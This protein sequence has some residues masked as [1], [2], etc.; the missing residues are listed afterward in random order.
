MGGCG[1]AA[2]VPMDPATA[3]R[4]HCGGYLVTVVAGTGNAVRWMATVHRGMRRALHE[5]GGQRTWIRASSNWYQVWK[6]A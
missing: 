4:T 5:T 1:Q 6:L 2:P 3:G